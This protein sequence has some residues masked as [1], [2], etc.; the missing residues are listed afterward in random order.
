[1]SKFIRRESGKRNMSKK[2]RN[3]PETRFY[4]IVVI[5]IFMRKRP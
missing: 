2:K 3:F 5:C 4:K 1:M